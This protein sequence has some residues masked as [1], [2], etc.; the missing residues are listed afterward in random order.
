MLEIDCLRIYCGHY[1]FTMVN[2]YY[3]NIVWATKNAVVLQ[4][5]FI[6]QKSNSTDYFRRI[7]TFLTIGPYKYSYL[8]TYKFFFAAPVY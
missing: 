7:V 6:S 1:I 8:L 5:L 2:P 3:G 4:K